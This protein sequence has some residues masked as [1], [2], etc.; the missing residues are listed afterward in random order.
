MVVAA[1]RPKEGSQ[2]WNVWIAARESFC[3]LEARKEI[4]YAHLQCA[5]QTT[6]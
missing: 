4:S 3:A 5:I 6:T 2:A 1:E